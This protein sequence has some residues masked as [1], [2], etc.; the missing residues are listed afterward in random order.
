MAEDDEVEDMG[1]NFGSSEAVEREERLEDA[2]WPKAVT[3]VWGLGTK[4]VAADWRFV[5]TDGCTCIW[6]RSSLESPSSAV[7]T[8]A[9]GSRGAVAGRFKVTWGEANESR[10]RGVDVEE[11]SST[12]LRLEE[13]HPFST[14]YFA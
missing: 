12:S 10:R 9:A 13:D 11:S 7:A 3:V 4:S 14:L 8:G 1:I 2:E 5:S 6:S